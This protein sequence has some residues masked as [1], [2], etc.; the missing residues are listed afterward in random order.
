MRTGIRCRRVGFL[1]ID[2]PTKANP[3]MNASTICIFCSFLNLIF[4]SFIDISMP[5]MLFILPILAYFDRVH[6]LTFSF[7]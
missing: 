2:I 5:V 3:M 1:M 7:F 4:R 6:T